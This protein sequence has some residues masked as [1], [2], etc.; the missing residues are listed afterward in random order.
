MRQAIPGNRIVDNR[1]LFLYFPTISGIAGHRLQLDVS[2]PDARPG[3]AP[4]DLDT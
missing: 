3:D 2:A 1:F 4:F